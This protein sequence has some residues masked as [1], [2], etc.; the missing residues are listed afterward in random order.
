MDNLRKT[1][2]VPKNRKSYI[3]TALYN[4]PTQYATADKFMISGIE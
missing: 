2:T 4:A 1:N 3:L